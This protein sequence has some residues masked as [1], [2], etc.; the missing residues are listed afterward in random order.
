[1]NKV[2]HGIICVSKIHLVSH[3]VH[4]KTESPSAFVTKS[5]SESKKD[6]VENFSLY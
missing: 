5:N 3:S 4:N 2:S 6:N 1:M